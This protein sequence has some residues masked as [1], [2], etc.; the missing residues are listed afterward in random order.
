MMKRGGNTSQSGSRNA[1][2]DRKLQKFIS[3]SST[4][5]DRK[6]LRTL[7]DYFNKADVQE[8]RNVFK[9][10]FHRVYGVLT[11][12][13]D[14]YEEIKRNDSKKITLRRKQVRPEGT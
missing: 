10:H 1:E 4:I 6:R 5:S 11:G 8:I 12:V 13:L 7:L 2:R 14:Q 3:N 9:D